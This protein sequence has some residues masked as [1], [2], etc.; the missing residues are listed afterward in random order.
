MD[1]KLARVLLD[2]ERRGLLLALLDDINPTTG[3]FVMDEIP[4][5]VG[6]VDI[7]SLA[8]DEREA[9]EAK[10]ARKKVAKG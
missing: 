8:Q 7:N 3:E 4:C 10:I 6:G 1:E 2:P 9:H 5:Y